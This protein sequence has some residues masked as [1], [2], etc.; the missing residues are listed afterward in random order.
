[1]AFPFLYMTLAI[2][3]LNGHGLSNNA[4]RERLPKKTKITRY[5]LQNYQAVA[6]IQSILFIKVSGQICSDAF[7]SRLAFGFT[8]IILA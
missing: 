8:V 4:C 1:M 7:K 2:D 3:K 6:T 5:Y